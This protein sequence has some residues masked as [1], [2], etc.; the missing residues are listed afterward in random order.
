MTK[1]LTRT[2]NSYAVIIERPILEETRIDESTALEIS[3]HGDVIV[4]SPVRSRARVSKVR[5]GVEAINRR[6]ARVFRRLAD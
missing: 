4:I 3:T 6:Y 2:G 5:R 1:R